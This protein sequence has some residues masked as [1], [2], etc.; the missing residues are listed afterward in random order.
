MP[1]RAR[2]RLLLLDCAW[3]VKPNAEIT[4]QRFKITRGRLRIELQ[5]AIT[6]GVLSALPCS[7]TP[8]GPELE[9][10]AAVEAR[11][12]GEPRK[13]GREEEIRKKCRGSVSHYAALPPRKKERK[14]LQNVCSLRTCYDKRRGTMRC[15]DIR[16]VRKGKVTPWKFPPPN[17]RDK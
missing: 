13:E 16:T 2:A 5:M 17:G 6:Y 11:E 9:G 7:N 14:C 4:S 15:W 10:R 1:A 3:I 8:K 12:T